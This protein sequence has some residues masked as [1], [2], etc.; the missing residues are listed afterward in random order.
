MQILQ[1]V[2]LVQTFKEKSH[3]A[4][5]DGKIHFEQL[6]PVKTVSSKALSG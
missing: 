5:G 4:G 3:G 1:T 6:W 2:F